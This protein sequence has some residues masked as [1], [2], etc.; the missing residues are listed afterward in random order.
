MSSFRGRHQDRASAAITLGAA[1]LH[2]GAAA[3]PSDPVKKD[4]AGIQSIGLLTIEA[5]RNR[6]HES[7]VQKLTRLPLSLVSD[8]RG[9]PGQVRNRKVGSTIRAPTIAVSDGSVSGFRRGSRNRMCIAVVSSSPQSL[10]LR[11]RSSP[12]FDLVPA[13]TSRGTS[14]RDLPAAWLTRGRKIAGRGPPDAVRAASRP[15]SA[16]PL[17]DRQGG[18]PGVFSIPPRPAKVPVL[19]CRRRGNGIRE[20]GLSRGGMGIW[21]SEPTHRRIGSHTTGSRTVAAEGRSPLT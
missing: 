3:V 2:S 16:A 8:L 6:C 19:A 20:R 10:D 9:L 12:R 17:Q 4:F 14:G 13:S 1:F 15:E 21:T 11:W 18:E 7:L 5:Q